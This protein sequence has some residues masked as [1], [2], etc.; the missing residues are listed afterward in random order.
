MREKAR[1][2]RKKEENPGQDSLLW[3]LP[4]ELPQRA[5]ALCPERR[6]D[7][8]A[9]KTSKKGLT[10]GKRSARIAG[11]SRRGREVRQGR[12]KLKN[13]WKPS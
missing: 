3:N 7:G 12:K 1:R 9:R 2:E 4:E 10:S 8:K 11:L 6:N 5:S 13:F